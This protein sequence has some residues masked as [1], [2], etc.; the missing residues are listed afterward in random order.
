M[1]T[2]SAGGGSIALGRRAAASS[3]SGPQ[4]AGAD[5]GPACYGRGGTQPTVTD[6]DIVCGFLNPDY[7]LGGTQTP[8]RRRAAEA[9]LETQIAEPLQ[10]SA[11]EAAAGIRRIVDMRMAD[12][13]RVFAAKR[14]RR[15]RA[16]SRCCRSAAPA[17]CMR[18]RSPRNSACARILV[19]PRPGRVLG[20]RAA[21]HRRACTTTSAPNCGRSP[22]LDRR[23]CRGDL[24]RAR[25]EARGRTG[26]RRARSGRGRRSRASS[27]CAIPARATNCA[28]RSTGCATSALDRGCAAPQRAR[29][30]T[31]GMRRSTATPRRRSR[32]R[33]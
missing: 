6:A 32:S 27:T 23:P 31:S 2:I 15:S 17:P 4:S 12:E 19:P 16:T 7:F 30:S 13:V 21:L 11:A 1:T 26:R 20:A 28:C 29:A 14:G 18:R 3:L 24:P 9:A 5:P 8:R 33:W 22:Q 10:M 25:G